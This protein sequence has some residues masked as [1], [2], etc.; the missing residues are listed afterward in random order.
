MRMGIVIGTAAIVANV[1]SIRRVHRADHRWKW[2]MTAINGGI[3]VL[4]MILV[5]VDVTRL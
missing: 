3:I 4:L 5:V 1:V 2:P